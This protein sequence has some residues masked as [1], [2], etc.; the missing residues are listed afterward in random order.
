MSSRR[1]IRKEFGEEVKDQEVCHRG[2][3]RP[4]GYC[5]IKRTLREVKAIVEGLNA[6]FVFSVHC[7][8]IQ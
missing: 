4:T 2:Y 5:G 6:Y 3:V 7:K 8:D 1:Q